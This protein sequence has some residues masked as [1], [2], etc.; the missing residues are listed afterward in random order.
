MYRHRHVSMV[1]VYRSHE[2]VKVVVIR[3]RRRC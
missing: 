1:L 2:M 3:P